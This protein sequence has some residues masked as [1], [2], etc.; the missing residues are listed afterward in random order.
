MAELKFFDSVQLENPDPYVVHVHLGVVATDMHQKGSDSEV[1]FPL[2][3]SKIN[4]SAK[5][6]M[7]QYKLM[8]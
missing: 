5:N 8:T 1:D 6:Q 2:D 3:D 4:L 7:H